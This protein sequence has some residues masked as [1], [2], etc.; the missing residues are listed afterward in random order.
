[1]KVGGRAYYAVAEQKTAVDVPAF[2]AVA[3]VGIMLEERYS[4]VE[5]NISWVRVYDVVVV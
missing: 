1:M 3:D 2:V 5:K 4:L